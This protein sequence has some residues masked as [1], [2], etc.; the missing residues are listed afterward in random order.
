MKVYI[1]GSL[2]DDA[3]KPTQTDLAM[4][5]LLGDHFQCIVISR[6]KNKEL[7]IDMFHKT[8]SPLYEWLGADWKGGD[9][10]E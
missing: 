9:I 7:H 10:N 5:K 6:D 8:P 4:E 3:M 1:D 2:F